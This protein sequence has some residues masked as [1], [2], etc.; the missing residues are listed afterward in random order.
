MKK[1]LGIVFLAVV[2]AGLLSSCDKKQESHQGEEKQVVKIGVS[3]PLSGDVAFAGVPVKKS[4]ELALRDL[5][6]SQNLKYDYRLV[7]EDDKLDPKQ[8]VLNMNRFGS[9]EKVNAIMS[10]WGI[11][12]PAVAKYANE[13][14]IIHFGCSWGYEIGKGYYSFN[15]STL[16]DEQ[17]DM[18]IKGLKNR[19]VKT[20]GIL[21]NASASDVEVIGIL[22]KKLA[23]EGITVAYK[24]MYAMNARDFKADVMKMKKIPVDIILIMMASPSLDIMAKQMKEGG[25]NVPLTSIDYFGFVPQLFEGQWFVQDAGGTSEFVEYFKQQTGE[26]ITSCVPNHYDSLR[27]IV[28]GFEKTSL[29]E[30]QKLPDHKKVVETILKNENFKSVMGKIWLDEEGNV[31]TIPTLQIIENGKPIKIE[32]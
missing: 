30:D 3:L 4:I 12:G 11:V 28:E 21:H 16:P 1:G 24:N 13:N 17:V 23:A 20:I 22:Q 29:K 19:Q 25:L 5:K 32:E 7:Y 31:H 10:M 18:L 2:A 14:E 27:M 26:N 9:V 8:T 15:N 6:K